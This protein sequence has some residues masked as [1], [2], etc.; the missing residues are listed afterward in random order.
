MK[1]ETENT[2]CL[3][4]KSQQG[5]KTAT[6]TLVRENEPLVKSIIKRFLGRGIDYDDLFQIG[7]IGLLKAISGFNPKF[8][9]R[10]STYAV[11]M[12]SGEVKRFVRDNNLVKMPRSLKEMQ[13]RIRYCRQQLTIEQGSE[14][15]VEEIAEKLECN[16][17]DIVFALDSMNACASLD[18]PAFE[19]EGATKMDMLADKKD[20][21]NLLDKIALRQCIDQLDEREKTVIFLRYYKDF[22][23]TRISEILGISQVQISRIESRTIEKLKRKL[24]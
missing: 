16:I 6:E 10:F 4:E 3:I 22:T 19:E 9:V 8:S 23:Q 5:D 12:I 7:N 15:T 11:P 13:Q 14:P 24:G 18:E 2:L 20:K 17:E 1:W 21:G